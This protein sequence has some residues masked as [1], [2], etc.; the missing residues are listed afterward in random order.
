MQQRFYSVWS[1]VGSNPLFSNLDLANVL[2]LS[3]L[4]FN[5]LHPMTLIHGALK[6]CA[7]KTPC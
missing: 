1:L 7:E 5:S 6:T 4:Y 3:P 2:P